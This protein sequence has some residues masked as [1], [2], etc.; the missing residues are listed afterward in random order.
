MSVSLP[1]D[2]MLMVSIAASS[3][4]D[5]QTICTA[6]DAEVELPALKEL[7]MELLAELLKK[8]KDFD[9]DRAFTEKEQLVYLSQRLNSRAE[10]F[11]E[12]A[13]AT[14][15]ALKTEVVPTQILTGFFEHTACKGYTNV[16]FDV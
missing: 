8:R 3:L 15:E 10:R 2:E 9:I 4:Q 6:E 16:A 11:Q 7:V 1:V 13:N 12:K 14:A 5:A